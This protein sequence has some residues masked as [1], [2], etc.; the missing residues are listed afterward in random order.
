[1]RFHLFDKAHNFIY[2][3]FDKSQQI[4]SFLKTISERQRYDFWIF[5]SYQKPKHKTKQKTYIG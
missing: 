1:M 2:L 5:F 4:V 3:L